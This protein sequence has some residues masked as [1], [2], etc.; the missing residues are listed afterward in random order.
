[1]VV[2]IKDVAGGRLGPGNGGLCTKLSHLPVV[3]HR[4][5]LPESQVRTYVK[6]VRPKRFLKEKACDRCNEVRPALEYPKVR[7]GGTADVCKSCKSKAIVQMWA[8]KRGLGEPSIESQVEMF[9]GVPK[10]PTTHLAEL[11]AI[12]KLSGARPEDAPVERPKLSD[13]AIDYDVK[14]V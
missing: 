6:P 13:I 2:A 7:G 1:M 9:G 5:L 4:R 14:K 11:A 3:R 8:D 12:A 10:D